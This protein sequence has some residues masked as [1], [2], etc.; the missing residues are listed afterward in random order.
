MLWLGD[1]SRPQQVNAVV[2]LALAVLDTALRDV[3]GRPLL[4]GAAVATVLVGAVPHPQPSPRPC[5]SSADPAAPPPARL[6][7]KPIPAWFPAESYQPP[8]TSVGRGN[9]AA[10]LYGRL[11]RGRP[12]TLQQLLLDREQSGEFGQ[13]SDQ[14]PV[15]TAGQ[16]RPVA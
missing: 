7:S 1:G 5:R 4:A 8:A 9:A 14:D 13:P 12:G 3:H 6:A 2:L 11:D 15:G 10:C 16:P